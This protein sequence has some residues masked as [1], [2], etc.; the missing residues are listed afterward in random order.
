MR[1]RRF[2]GM[3]AAL[4]ATRL[5]PYS[6]TKPVS[7]SDAWANPATADPIRDVNDMLDA[8]RY[9]YESG[10]GVWY[11]TSAAVAST[12][13][14]SAWFPTSAGDPVEFHYLTE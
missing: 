2:L 10:P 3:L 9:A 7:Y 11:V 8:M 5:V 1:R 12:S 6:P 14:L 4:P 13:A